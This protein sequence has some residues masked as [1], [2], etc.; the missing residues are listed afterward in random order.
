MA[1]EI[2]W[3][4]ARGKQLYAF[5]WRKSDNKI[6]NGDDVVFET[7]TDVNIDDY[8]YKVNPVGTVGAKS[9][10]Y[11]VDFQS[12]L[13]ADTYDIQ[14]FKQESDISHTPHADNDIVIAQ[15]TLDWDG[16]EEITITG[17][18]GVQ[19]RVLNVY[20]DREK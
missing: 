20:D 15:G 11:A 10:R 2:W 6:W 18:V 19:A 4:Y 14:I 17:M 9:Q 16:E 3:S 1:N 5:I 7:F 12:I 13:P 8:V